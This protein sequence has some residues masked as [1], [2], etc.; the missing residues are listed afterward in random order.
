[1]FAISF[2][3]LLRASQVA[4]QQLELAV[5]ITNQ[6]SKGE[7]D[8]YVLTLANDEFA[9]VVIKQL[10]L[11]V[12]VT[13][14]VQGEKGT[15]RVD[16]A[17]GSS[18]QEVIFMIGDGRPCRFQLST[19][20]GNPPP[21]R[22]QIVVEER[23]PA[24]TLD[25][26]NVALQ[27]VFFEAENLRKREGNHNWE[28]AI[29]KLNE[30]I[31]GE[32][33]LGD[34]HSEALA[35]RSRGATYFYLNMMS[36]SLASYEEA[37][38]ILGALPNRLDEA[39]TLL[40][41]GITQ[42]DMSDVVNARKS[43]EGALELFQAENDEKFVGSTLYQMGRA[44]YLL[45]DLAQALNFYEQA[46]PLR[47]RHDQVGEAFTLVGMGRVYANGFVDYDQA[48]NFYKRALANLTPGLHRRLMAQVLGDIGKVYFSQHEFDAALT[49]YQKALEQNADAR[50]TGEILMYVGMVYAA[51]GDNEKALGNFTDA[52]GLQCKIIEEAGVS[53][54]LKT[55]NRESCDLVGAGHT[56]KNIGL[57]YAAML[58]YDKALDHLDQALQIWT[59][60]LYRTAEADTRYEIARIE[61]RLGDLSQARVQIETA[62]PIVESLRARI[63]NQHLR[64]SYFASAQKFYELYIDVLMRQYAQSGDRSLQGVALT[65]SERARTRSMLDTLVEARAEVRSGAKAEDLDREL[66]LQSRLTLLS[67]R[68][69]I[70]PRVTEA[71]KNRIRQELAAVVADYHALEA[72]IRETSPRYAGLTH[73]ESLS[74]EAIQRLLDPDQ[75]LLEYA[76][77]EERSYLWEVT[78]QSVKSHE[79]PK[80][81]EIEQASNKVRRLLI[82]R[83][84]EYVETARELSR[85]L[86]GPVELNNGSPRLLIVTSGSLQYLSFAALPVSV[87]TD[88]PLFDSSLTRR[89]KTVP[90]LVYHEIETAPSVSVLAELRRER[91]NSAQSINR[92][93]V[94]V[95]ADPVFSVD[96]RFNKE[97]A[98][99]SRNVPQ[100]NS[101]LSRAFNGTV[102]RLIFT[103]REANAIL[104]VLPPGKVGEKVLDFEAKRELVTAPAA[105]S[106]YRIIHFATH[107][108]I[109]DEYPELSGILLSMIDER[110]RPQNGLLQMHEIY[111]LNIPAELVVLSGC[112]TSIGKE[113]KGEGLPGLSRAFI[114]AGARRVIASLWQVQDASTADLMRVFYQKLFN[115]NGT[116]TAAA[117]REAQLEMWK[118][119]P[120]DS[121]HSWAAFIT[122]GDSRY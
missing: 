33:A 23:R 42:L 4:N 105:L 87:R 54:T 15:T 75:M 73:P 93:Q 85:I 13:I 78:R 98:R 30:V 74:V 114:Y 8:S 112:E 81:S 107:G 37:L 19:G 116:R 62:F 52:L 89:L 25:R 22:Y 119:A 21:G 44:S 20:A 104:S 56:I 7:V 77:G 63:A 64:T 71:E 50:V 35:L 96:D 108:V 113:M 58:N 82:E 40:S 46:L 5:P 90:L 2:P 118:K 111:N 32:H 84:P 60:V 10:G 70:D 80:R 3:T 41:M 39:G 102:P 1:M 31:K 121:P 34:R 57:A 26:Q 110:R 79:L 61:Q 28:S 115:Q 97:P 69:M 88:Q 11:D 27:N 43:L 47:H 29:I 83:N 65:Y 51:K 53:V 120:N 95:I 72:R 38:E 66:A 55:L 94:L 91:I 45:G 9:K 101:G 68:Q 100:A 18:G 109:N 122:Y 36:Q 49:E 59:H 17:N 16:G 14:E 12:A 6:V 24:T 67:Q 99:K 86:L 106:N 48:L 76:F 92:K 103:R 117:L